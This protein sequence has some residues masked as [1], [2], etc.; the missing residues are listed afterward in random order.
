MTKRLFWPSK[1]LYWGSD[2]FTLSNGYF[3]FS[4][5]VGTQE[6]KIS[7]LADPKKQRL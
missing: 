4:R 5:E 3:E 7:S 6:I 1:N 2:S